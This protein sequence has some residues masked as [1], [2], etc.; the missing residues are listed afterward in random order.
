MYAD[1]AGLY[2]QVTGDG[3]AKVAKPLDLSLQASR[4]SARDGLG[5][6]S[7]IEF[8]ASNWR[9]TT[10]G[11]FGMG[12]RRGAY[13]V[14][15]CWAL[16]LLL[17]AGGVMNLLWIAG[18]SVVVIIEKMTPLPRLWMGDRC[19]SPYAGH[20]PRRLAPVDLRALS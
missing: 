14:G 11:T 18:L 8:L 4:R 20:R 17:F 6:R 1:G 12:L 10:G 2:L 13:R 9:A 15:W 16:M 3:E 5:C 7:P 19:C